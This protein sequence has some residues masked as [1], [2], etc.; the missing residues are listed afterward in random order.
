MTVCRAGAPASA[1]R[2]LRLRLYRA[3]YCIERK[4][5]HNPSSSTTLS[6]AMRSLRRGTTWSI[7]ANLLVLLR[8]VRGILL[9]YRRRCSLTGGARYLGGLPP[10]LLLRRDGEVLRQRA[11]HT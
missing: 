3:V 5:A 8:A 1:A 9:R 6:T 4:H 2:A 10:L 11:A 7:A